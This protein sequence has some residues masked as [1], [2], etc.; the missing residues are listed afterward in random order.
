MEAVR[1]PDTLLDIAKCLAFQVGNEVSINEVAR[2]AKTD[3]KTA[4]KYLDLL[5]KMFIIRKVRGF[6]R[7]LRNEISKKPKYYFLDN[8]VRNAVI[9][10]FNPLSLRNDIG[11]LWEN[12]IFME[13]V[14]KTGIEEKYDNFYFW[15]T[16]TGQEIDIIKE[17]NGELTAI[18]CKWSNIDVS[19]P[20]LWKNTYPGARFEVIHKDNYLDFLL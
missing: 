4:A 9:S 7:N 20:T 17:T 5:E 16:H 12:F 14:K 19:A 10:Q 13:L 2:T 15:R 11:A 8:G 18:E 6:S 3:A 1:S